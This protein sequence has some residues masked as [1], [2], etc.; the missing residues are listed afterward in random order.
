[1]VV[2]RVA[3]WLD[4]NIWVESSPVCVAVWTLAQLNRLLDVYWVDGSFD[5]TCEELSRAEP[6]GARA[7]RPRAELLAHPGVAVV[8]L[9]QFSYGAAGHERYAG[10]VSDPDVITLLRS[11]AQSLR[12]FRKA[13]ARVALIT[14]FSA[15][16]GASHFRRLAWQRA[17]GL[18]EVHSWAF[19]RR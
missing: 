12:F 14:C 18:V 5:K 10:W 13:C 1:L 6:A 8:R 9:L 16:A 7:E 11:S 3:D 17:I 15:R 4:R 2:A 19:N